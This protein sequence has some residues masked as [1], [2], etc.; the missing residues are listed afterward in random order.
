MLLEVNVERRARMKDVL[1]SP[2]LI[3]QQDLDGYIS[4]MK[5]RLDVI[6]GRKAQNDDARPRNGTQRAAAQ[7]TTPDPMNPREEIE[8]ILFDYYGAGVTTN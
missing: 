6:Q 4:E 2:Y 7:D 1:D 3:K 8:N 5:G